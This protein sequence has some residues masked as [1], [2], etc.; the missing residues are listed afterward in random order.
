[1][2]PTFHLIPDPLDVI[3]A[4]NWKTTL[5]NLFEVGAN[6]NSSITEGRDVNNYLYDV[7]LDKLD[8]IVNQIGSSIKTISSEN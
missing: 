5:R 1:M 8:N 7:K 4:N 2:D 3:K 6:M